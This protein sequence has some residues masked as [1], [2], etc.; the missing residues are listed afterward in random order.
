MDNTII[1]GG[2]ITGLSL[3]IT[4]GF[5]IY[6]ALGYPGGICSSY[7]M[8]AGEN[9]RLHLYPKDKEAYRFE[10]GGGHWIFGNNIHII[11][12]IKFIT[13]VSLY[14]RNSAVYFPESGKFIPYPIQ[15]HLSFL[16]QELISKILSE[17][18]QNRTFLPKIFTFNEWLRSNFGDTLTELFFGPFHQ[19]YTANLYKKIAPQDAYKSPVNIKNVLEGAFSK[20]PPVGYNTTFIYPNF[21][22]DH[23]T[24]EMA[25][26]C[27]IEY[28]KLITNIDIKTKTIFFKDK[29]KCTY[30]QILSTLPLNKMAQLTSLNTAQKPDPCTSVLVL[31]IGATKGVKCPKEHWL[32]IPSSKGNFHRVGFYSN[33]D[34]SFLPLSSRKLNNRVSIYVEK[35]FPEDKKPGK[36]E[37][38][39][40]TKAIINEL[41][42]WRWI[43]KVEV[44]DSTWID[45]AYT[46]N[47][48]SSIW[49]DDVIEKLRLSD[50][51]QIGRYGTW[52]FQGILDSIK[53]GFIAGASF[54]KYKK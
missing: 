8:R 29:S 1:L 49:K 23:L 53:D 37:L 3:G 45:V 43:K 38:I 39:A 33:V 34:K 26:L 15:N 2:G 14:N 25:R 40:Q 27:N 24:N 54:R 13:P 11:Q 19:L 51:Y 7:Y 31:N 10:L 44:Q 5:K 4:T 36:Q 52:N 21:G 18:I 17:I 42:E 28:N 9:K 41:I 48:P 12:F 47:W 50:I 35:A 22:L 6:E 32:Y 30:D 46:W 20:L 16:E